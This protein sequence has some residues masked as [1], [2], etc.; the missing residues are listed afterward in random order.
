VRYIEV[1]FGQPEEQQVFLHQF[2]TFPLSP[3]LVG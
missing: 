2:H 1:F 3:N